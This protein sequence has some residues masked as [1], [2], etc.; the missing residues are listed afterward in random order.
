MEVYINCSIL[1]KILEK[2][3]FWDMCQN[4]FGQ[5]DCRIFKEILSLE[6]KD[7]KAWCFACGYK[8]IEVKS[9]SKNIGIVL[10]INGY[11]HSG[12]RNRKLAV[13]HKEINGINWFLVFWYEL[14][15]A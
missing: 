15:K 4:V 5:S 9:R 7:K 3:G 11:A 1:G 13:S 10:V 6:R 8:F 14:R 12:L 2:F